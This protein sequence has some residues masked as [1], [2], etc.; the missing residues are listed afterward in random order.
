MKPL[1]KDD[2][3][4]FLKRFENFSGAEFRSIKVNSATSMSVKFGVQDSSREFD[5]I[6]VELEFSGINDAKLLEDSKLSYVDMDDGVTLLAGSE[7]FSFAIGNYDPNIT[8]SICYI[9]SSSLK[10]KEGT[11]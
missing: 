2:L 3:E 10:Y 6:S 4:N 11:F 9:K 8:D 5:W 1:L 7:G